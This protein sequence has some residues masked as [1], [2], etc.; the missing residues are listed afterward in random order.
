MMVVLFRGDPPG[1]TIIRVIIFSLLFLKMSAFSLTVA[2]VKEAAVVA[3]G[4]VLPEEVLI[5]IVFPVIVVVV[6]GAF[7]V[8]IVPVAVVAGFEHIGRILVVAAAGIEITGAHG[9]GRGGVIVVI[10][11][12][13]I[14]E[15][16]FP[17]DL[18]VLVPALPGASVARGG[19]IVA[20]R[21]V[22][23]ILPL[24]VF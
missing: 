22:I 12:V 18:R 23:T 10:T 11:V 15:I 5:V 20:G 16:I 24:P 6:V 14:N 21:T 1:D 9:I 19:A 17:E 13:V 4:F 7:L 2:Y 8:C 3:T